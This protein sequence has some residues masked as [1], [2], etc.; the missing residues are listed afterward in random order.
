[1]KKTQ[2]YAEIFY[3]GT[4]VAE[5]E[6][7]KIESKENFKAPPKCYGYRF[8]ERTVLAEGGEDLLGPKKN[9]SSF[10]FFGKEYTAQEYLKEKTCT[11]IAKQ[12]IE[13]NGY[14][15]LVVTHFGQLL[16]LSD[17]DVVVSE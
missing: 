16:P 8:F 13:G 6:E 1:M 4:F 15:R 11:V 3:P 2:I 14:K 5:I 9:F 10:T 12:N 17:G 7:K